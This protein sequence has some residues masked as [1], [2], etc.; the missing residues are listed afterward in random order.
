MSPVSR[1]DKPTLKPKAVETPAKDHKTPLRLFRKTFQS[2]QTPMTIIMLVVLAGMV[3]Y[4]AP[5][6]GAA[7]APDNVVARVYGREILLRDV[8]QTLSDM[9][10]RMGNQGNV[11]AM[12]PFLQ[13]QAL[14]RTVDLKLFEELAERHG[15][16]VTDQE[17]KTGLEN[18]LRQY[19]VFL[20]EKGNL[21]SVEDITNILREN[22]ITLMQWEQGMRDQLVVQKLME[23]VSAQVP[24]DEGW[25]ALENRIENEKISFEFAVLS[26][27][28]AAVA[29]PGDAT[30][31]T[32]LKSAGARFQFGPR[33]VLQVVAVDQATFASSLQVDD[34]SLK[35]AYEAKKSQ[36]TELDASHI[37][38]QAKTESEFAEAL[39]KATDLRAKLAAGGDFGKAAADVSQDPTAKTNRGHLGWFKTG[40]MVKPFEDAALALKPGEISQ[41]V[42]TSFGIHL[43]KLEGR[44]EK[45]FEEV[46]DELKA[47]MMKDRFATRA[48]DR[49][50][51]LRKRAGD[52]GDLSTPAKNL[53]L[54]VKNTLPLLNDPAT[55][56]EGLAEPASVVDQA[57]RMQVGEVSKVLQSGDKY[58]VFRVQQELPIAIPPLAEIRAKVL[59]AWKLEEARKAA[60]EKAK[61][62]LAAKN[63]ALLAAP[64]T[65]EA[66]TIQSLAPLGDQPAI[67]KAL[68]ET[69]VDGFTPV[70]WTPEGQVWLA[71][72]KARTPAEAPTFEKR[73]AMVQ[74]LQSSISQQLL[75][76]ERKDLETKGRQHA[77]FSSL[78]GRFGGIWMNP[79]AS[80]GNTEDLPVDLGD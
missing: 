76:A 58:V 52:K 77:G 16:V 62:A 50:E 43:I 7:N 44:R 39:Q 8:Q 49:L 2:N 55:T 13:S 53:N 61:A 20:D 60:A 22:G 54:T 4:L 66:V 64:A 17:V 15:I 37:L 29:D 10:R 47:Q 5:S 1:H 21:K 30:L 32:Y 35:A 68:L 57:F 75:E 74:T 3:A 48:K 38:F 19:P 78:W 72:I 42:R 46:K 79:G 67:R 40:S 27:D 69:A 31:D 28:T 63:L 41:P 6:R 73:A 70:L 18:K 33:R 65:K 59:S 12:M 71:R 45:T 24:V 51:Q 34:A 56:I 11:K 9:V 26:P 23:Q 36:Y 14:R 80:L 25:L